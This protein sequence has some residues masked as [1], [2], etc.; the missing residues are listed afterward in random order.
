MLWQNAIAEHQLECFA[1][2]GPMWLTRIE[3]A[4]VPTGRLTARAFGLS[5][6]PT[7]L[8][9]AEEVIAWRCFLLRCM[10]SVIGT[11]RRIDCDA[12]MRSQADQ[13]GHS[14]PQRAD[15]I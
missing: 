8:A 13:S 5:V 15:C 3:A 1:S 6:P 14:L 2:P 10:M 7:L 4:I 12:E 9:R 11:K